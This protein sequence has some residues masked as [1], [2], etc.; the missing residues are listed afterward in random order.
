M[1]FSGSTDVKGY[2][3]PASQSAV[4]VVEQ[5]DRVKPQVQPVKSGTDS[6]KIALN[7]QSLH[8]RGKEEQAKKMSREEVE[9]VMEQVQVRLDSIGANLKLGLREYEETSD[10]IVQVKD[11]TNGELVKQFPS[12]ELLKLQAKLDDLMGLLVDRKA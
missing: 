10:I 4:P 1:E 8:G 12:E 3:S 2:V 6:S 9:K 11:R 7:D 5:E